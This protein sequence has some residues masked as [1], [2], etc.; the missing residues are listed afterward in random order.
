[1]EPVRVGKY[2]RPVEVG[3]RD[4]LHGRVVAVVDHLRAALRRTGLEI[5]DPEVVPAAGDEVRVD[6]EPAQVV[7]AGLTQ[8]MAGN[9]GD[10]VSLE[11]QPGEHDGGVSLTAREADLKL[12][13]LDDALVT[14]RA[15]AHHQLTEGDHLGPASGHR[16][17]PFA[18]ST[19]AR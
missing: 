3:G 7:D 16:T 18:S 10:R 11:S 2:R 13:G 17:I 12:A 8:L 1:M 9:A 6:A 15:Q 4:A 14:G 19:R 5:H